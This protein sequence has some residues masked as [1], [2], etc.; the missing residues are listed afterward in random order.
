MF[1]EALKDTDVKY[2]TITGSP[3]KSQREYKDVSLAFN[4]HQ[5]VL[6]NENT[7]IKNQSKTPSK[8]FLSQE[9]A[10]RS[11]KEILEK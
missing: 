1:K 8:V 9:S 3:I 5:E 2:N 11:V 10:P 7:L 6:I 4:N